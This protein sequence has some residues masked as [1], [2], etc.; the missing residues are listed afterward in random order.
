MNVPLFP[1]L[2]HNLLLLFFKRFLLLVLSGVR[3]VVVFIMPLES[4]LQCECLETDSTAVL[5]L[6]GL[7]M[8]LQ[9][10]GLFKSLAACL[11]LV[12]S[13][14][15]VYLTMGL[16]V[17]GE[18]GLIVTLLAC[19]PVIVEVLGLYVLYQHARYFTCKAA[20]LELARHYV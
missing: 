9:S 5:M 2:L 20:V 7:V 13:L 19:V 6:M 16:V 15:C 8:D 14:S 4:Q 11:T 12:R 18:G 3:T 1:V 10:I 17:G